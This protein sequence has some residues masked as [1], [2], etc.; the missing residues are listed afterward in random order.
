MKWRMNDL[1]NILISHAELFYRVAFHLLESREEAEDAVQELYLKLYESKHRLMAV[2]EPL[3]YGISVLRNICIDRIRRRTVRK[4]EPVDER[5]PLEEAPPDS[6]A[7]SKD[8]LESLMTEIDKLPDRQAVVLK[9]KAVEGLDYNEI[10]ETTG[11]SQVHVR[12]LVSTARKT[13]KRRLR[14]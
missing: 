4:A 10:A 1:D 2:S 7:V 11:L 3:A 8:L 13:L 14:I 5:I 12:V 6:R 9:M